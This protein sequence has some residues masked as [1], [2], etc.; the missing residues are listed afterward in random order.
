MPSVTIYYQK[1]PKCGETWSAQLSQARVLRVGK[2]AFVCKCGT[3]W[4]TGRMEWI[5]LNT[6]QR[7]AYFVSTAEIGVLVICLLAPALF[8]YFIGN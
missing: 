4:P 2:E 7:R 1:C 3:A 8:G 6:E 5:H